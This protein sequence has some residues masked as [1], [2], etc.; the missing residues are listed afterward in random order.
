MQIEN[1]RYVSELLREDLR[2][3]GFF[4]ETSVAGAT[5]SQPDPCSTTPTGWNGTPTSFGLPTPVQGYGPT[6]V[7]A[8]LANRKA[9]TDVGSV[10][11]VPPQP[12][13]ATL[14]GSGCV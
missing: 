9:G 11:G 7:L 4:G 12:A 2:L 10:S 5:Y 14:H 1:G 3:A 8:C 13:G 6:D